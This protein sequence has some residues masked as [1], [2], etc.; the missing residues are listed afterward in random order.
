MADYC[1][2]DLKKIRDSYF[3]AII[4]AEVESFIC[5]DFDETQVEPSH[6]RCCV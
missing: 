4:K 2:T 6:E 5:W 1:N 3:Q